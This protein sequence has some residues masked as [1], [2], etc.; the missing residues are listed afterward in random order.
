MKTGTKS[1][2]YG[3]HQVLWHPVTVWMAWIWL[4]RKLPT[5]RECVC[6][7]VHDLGY[8]GKS[9]MDGTEGKD[10]PEGGARI[11]ERLLGKEYGD[12]V[13]YHSRSYAA[14]AGQPPSALCWPDK[15]AILF[16]PSWFYLPRVIASGEIHEYRKLDA[17]HGDRPE[18][19]SHREWFFWLRALQAEA[20][21]AQRGDVPAIPIGEEA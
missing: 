3:A 10:H 17:E 14:K 1:L 2:L 4:Y 7:V 19:A 5:W 21:L 6:I 12:L 15:L 16:D 13:R 9:N 18:N 20:G 11:A 8:F